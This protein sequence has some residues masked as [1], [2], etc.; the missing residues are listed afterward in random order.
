MKII[1]MGLAVALAAVALD[2]S[3]AAE[4]RRPDLEGN[5]TNATM[6]PQTR[7]AQYGPRLVM[8]PE[9]VAKVEQ[10]AQA[11]VERG[12]QRTDPNAPTIQDGTVGGYNRGFLDPGMQVMRVRGEP[13][14]SLITTPDGQIP[15]PHAASKLTAQQMRAF[16]GSPYYLD[17]YGA[18]ALFGEDQQTAQRFDNPEEM[19]LADRCLT[20]FGRNGPPPMFPNGFYNNNYSIVQGTDAVV[21]VVEM[22]HDA[23]VIRLGSRQHQPPH[24][25]PW[26]GDSVGWYE[27]DTLVVETTN[28]PRS[29]AFFGAWEDLKVTE[30]FRRVA[31]DRLAYAFTVEAPSVWD[32]PW[33]GEYEFAAL[34]GQVYEY[35]CHEG[36]Y[37]MPGILGGSREADRAQAAAPAK[38][39]AAP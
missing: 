6:T 30:R 10:A 15:A 36:N 11:Q 7:P 2:A 19:S 35:A 1:G 34:D 26:F 16:S 8:T 32:K 12:N 23:R 18:A 3:A 31:K 33:G 24:L 13:R 28:F 29:Q 17:Q 38:A 5:W 14:T 4:A 21:I 22:V 27:G 39:G 20:S 37:A 25:R 9:E